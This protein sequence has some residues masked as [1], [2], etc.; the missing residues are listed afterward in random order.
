MIFVTKSALSQHLT[1]DIGFHAGT[2]TIISDYGER[3]N[4]LSKYGGSAVSISFTH[5]L[6]FFNKDLRWNAKHWLRD[7]LAFR[8][9]LN[10]VTNANFEHHGYSARQNTGE[11]RRLRAMTGKT[12]VVSIGF[13]LEYYIRSLKEFIYPWSDQKWNPYVLAGLQYSIFHN[14]VESSLGNWREDIS[15]LP[16]KWT[17]PQALNVGSGSAL[18]GTFGGGIRHKLTPKIDFNLQFNWQYFFSDAVDGLTA[19]VK[20]N[21]YNE[22]IINLQMGILF[23]L[24]FNS[25]L[26][27]S[28]LF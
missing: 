19:P 1:H 17:R 12:R 15:V 21:K 20:E 7:R 27:L 14:N 8:S 16:G 2:A 4:L 9:E 28:T 3:D 23:H 25:P 26:S 6:H 18:A 22:W 5:T 10:F 24:N 13:Q 11:G